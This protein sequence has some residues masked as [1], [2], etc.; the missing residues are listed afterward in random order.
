MGISPEKNQVEIV[1]RIGLPYRASDVDW[2][3]PVAIDG[4]FV[5]LADQRGVDSFQALMLAQSLVRNLLR[6][7][8]SKGGVLKDEDGVSVVDVTR[9]FESGVV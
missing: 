6:D 8:V 5:S 1:I 9:L 3:C 4:L 2:A 7:F